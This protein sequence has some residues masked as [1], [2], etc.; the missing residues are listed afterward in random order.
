MKVLILT[1][2]VPFPQNGGYPIVVCNTIRGLINLGHQVSLIALNARKHI[3]EEDEQD[4]LLSK[5][6]YRYYDI[7]ISMSM[8]DGFLTTFNRKAYSITRYYDEEFEK[9]LISEIKETS[10]DIIQFEG[11]FVAP[12]ID[13]VRRNCKSKLVY[14]AHNIE[15]QIWER[16]ALQKS[17]PFKKFYLKLMA[18]R[19][20]RYEL[21]QINKFDAI[22]AF[23]AQDK[24]TLMMYGAKI[25][26][27]VVPF[28]IDLSYYN[29]DLSKTEFPSLF[30]LGS[31]EWM[32]NRE[33]IEWF[34][35]TFYSDF[36]N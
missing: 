17:D 4:E 24:S 16:L 11:L 32:P 29:P 36:V 21:Q 34:L 33:G 20:K 5:I 23:T 27:E 2:R 6:N 9:V 19:I 8:F 18:R 14:R 30:F 10:Y 1:H 15:H 28:G 31:L 13:A 25:P 22:A 7:D 3:H 26:V 12:Y 35:H